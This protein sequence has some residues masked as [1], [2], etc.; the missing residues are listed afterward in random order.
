[1]SEES[2]SQ[3]GRSLP[4]GPE[5]TALRSRRFEIVR[6]EAGTV[7]QAV[8]LSITVL[9]ASAIALGAVAWLLAGQALCASGDVRFVAALV[10]ANTVQLNAPFT[11]IPGRHSWWMARVSAAWCKAIQ[12]SWPKR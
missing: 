6:S 3:S 10:D 2:G 5:G 4:S 8:G 12:R 1:M 9:L 11:L 7:L